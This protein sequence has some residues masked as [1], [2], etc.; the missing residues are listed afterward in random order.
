MILVSHSSICILDVV[1]LLNIHDIYIC[2]YII[3][4]DLCNVCTL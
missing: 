1:L 3:Y 2:T 4:Y